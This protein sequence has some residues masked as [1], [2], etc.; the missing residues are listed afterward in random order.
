MSVSAFQFNCPSCN[1]TFTV[2]SSKQGEAAKC[3]HCG[4]MLRIPSRI[5]P[6]YLN[7]PRAVAK[8]K[9]KIAES[10]PAFLTQNKI[11]FGCVIAV[12]VSILFG[13]IAP[14]PRADIPQ[15]ILSEPEQT[16]PTDSQPI[17]SPTLL[18][19]GSVAIAQT[20][21]GDAV[22][23]ASDYPANDLMV[24]YAAAHDNFGLRQLAENGKLMLVE[25]GTKI[26]IIRAHVFTFEVRILEG[27]HAM[28]EAVIA[29][30]FVAENPAQ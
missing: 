24:K 23:L 15:A 8:P 10:Q 28:R 5:E 3:Q 1:Y 11:V 25:S 17:K 13:L 18:T 16:K 21:N 26:R 9:A 14:K 20:K 6:I 29:R 30:D 22:P 4:E 12:S 7:E 19:S 27:K 2:R